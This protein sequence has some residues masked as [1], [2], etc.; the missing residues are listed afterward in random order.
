ML[1]LFIYLLTSFGYELEGYKRSQ[2]VRS[3]PK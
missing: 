1:V 3:L 2:I